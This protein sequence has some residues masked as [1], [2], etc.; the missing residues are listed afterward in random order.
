MATALAVVQAHHLIWT[1]EEDAPACSCGG[2]E[3]ETATRDLEEHDEHLAAKIES[4][5]LGPVVAA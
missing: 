1:S 3:P 5:L 4:A 2:W